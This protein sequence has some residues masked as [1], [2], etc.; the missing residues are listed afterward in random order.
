VNSL[1]RF[2]G[3]PQPQHRTSA[4]RPEEVLW[5][6][7]FVVIIVVLFLAFREIPVKTLAKGSRI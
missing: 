7:L 1:G 6:Y 2:E 3:V 5:F 4:Q